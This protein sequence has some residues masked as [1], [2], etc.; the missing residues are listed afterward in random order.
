MTDN[1]TNQNQPATPPVQAQPTQPAQQPAPAATP[2]TPQASPTPP[3]P[4]TSPAPSDVPPTPGAVQTVQIGKYRVE[5]I[6]DKCIGAASCVAIA[7]QVFQLNEDNI[8]HV[9]SQD[10]NDDDTKLL[11]AQSCP[12]A[13]I[14]VTDTTT[15]QKVWP[16]D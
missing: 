12:T 9:I 13:A 4:S 14:V 6:N 1:S 8:A 16:L 5:V 10:G 7:P 3:T 15:G 11:A 2:S